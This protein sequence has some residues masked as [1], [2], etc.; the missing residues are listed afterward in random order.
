MTVDEAI[1][2]A[3]AMIADRNTAELDRRAL[4]LLLRVALRGR[5][6]SDTRLPA[7]TTAVQHF[8]KAQ[9]HLVEGMGE[10]ARAAGPD[11][12]EPSED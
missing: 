7:V 8:A 1:E 9:E 5:H 6:I 3:R 11:E 12:E 10:I 4:E 2:R